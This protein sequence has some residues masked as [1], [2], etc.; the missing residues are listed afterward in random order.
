MPLQTLAWLRRPTELMSICRARYG[1]AFTLHLPP[2]RIVFLADPRDIRTVFTARADQMHAGEANRI[3]RVLVGDHS[4]LLLDREEHMRQRKLLLPS[5]HGERM[6]FYGRTM[7][8]VTRRNMAT[9]PEDEPFSLHAHTQHVTLE[10]ILRTVFGVDEG[11]RLEALSVQMKRLLARAENRGSLLLVAYISTHPELEARLPWSYLLADRNRT[12]RMLYRQI[13]ERRA[14]RNGGDRKDVLA[15]LL[16]ARDD[17]GHGMTDVELRDELMTALAAGHE[18]TATALA[19]AVERILSKPEIHA[20]LT[21]EIPP[22]TRTR[23]N[24]SRTASSACSRIPTLGFR[25]AAACG[26]ASARPSPST[27]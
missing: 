17:E 23:K 1:P 6:R 11:A 24:S 12:D 25:S 9:W 18:T 15:M 27:K 21:R 16:E 8:D 13:A 4:V 2:D 22:S 20:R 7:A 10:V 5:F 14:D 19:W 3:I 26:A